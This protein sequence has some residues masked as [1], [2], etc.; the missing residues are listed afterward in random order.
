LTLL[1]KKL[2]DTQAK[3]DSISSFA[4]STH[5]HSTSA[6]SEARSLYLELKALSTPNIDTGK[7]KSEAQ[8]AAAEVINLSH[9]IVTIIIKFFFFF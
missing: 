9:V 8:T 1:E 6:Y 5:D 7:I 3:L 4:A 2:Q